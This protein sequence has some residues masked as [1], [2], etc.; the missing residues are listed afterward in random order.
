[1]YQILCVDRHLGPSSCLPVVNL[2]H[3]HAK[4]RSLQRGSVVGIDLAGNES[5]FPND[6]FVPCFQHAHM[7]GVNA[8]VHAGEMPDTTAESVYQAV[9]EMHAKRIGHGYA[10]AANASVVQLLK[11]RNVFIEVCP[12]TCLE[13]YSAAH[14]DCPIA[15]FLEVG[16]K[17]F[18]INTDD[19]TLW[20][21]SLPNEESKAKHKLGLSMGIIED[22][23]AR[24][25]AARFA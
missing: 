19:P 4:A 3:A 16:L 23:Y 6:P 10:A 8:T 5:A 18:G 9:V 24:A 1:M 22:G 17:N 20:G 11:E 14:E 13:E 12:S 25:Y 21:T 7:L 2:A 15:K